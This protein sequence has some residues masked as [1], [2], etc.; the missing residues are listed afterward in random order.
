MHARHLYRIETEAMDRDA[1]VEALFAQGIGTGVHYRAVHLHRYYRER[2]DLRPESFPQATRASE[3]T[4]SLPLT[5]GLSDEA[6]ERTIEALRST[7]ENAG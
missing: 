7:I 2:Y 4:L 1:L 6:Q 5:A 3:R